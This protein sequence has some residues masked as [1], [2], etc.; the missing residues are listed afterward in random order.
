MKIHFSAKKFERNFEKT[1]KLRGQKFLN[2]FNLGAVVAHLPGEYIEGDST[3]MKTQF[4][5]ELFRNFLLVAVTFRRKDL[6]TDINLE[7]CPMFLFPGPPPDVTRRYVIS[8]AGNIS[9]PSL[10]PT[11]DFKLLLV[12]KE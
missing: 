11:H 10:K 1:F 9:I 5:K 7:H 8:T 6:G 12:F 2:I 3:K 4:K